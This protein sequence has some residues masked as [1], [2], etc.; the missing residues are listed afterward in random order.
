MSTDSLVTAE[1][2]SVAGANGVSYA[3]R[4]AGRSA[5]GRWR[6]RRDPDVQ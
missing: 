6:L 2:L 4:P 3:Y 1:T 5:R